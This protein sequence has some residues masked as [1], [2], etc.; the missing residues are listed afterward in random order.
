M[1][2]RLKKFFEIKNFIFN[3]QIIVLTL[4]WKDKLS[5]FIAKMAER[6]EA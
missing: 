1:R 5:I 2:R 6:S 3:Q 4:L